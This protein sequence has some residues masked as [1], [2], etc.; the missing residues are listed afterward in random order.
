MLN[1]MIVYYNDG[2]TDIFKSLNFGAF[3]L[4]N[5]VVPMFGAIVFDYDQKQVVILLDQVKKI[6]FDLSEE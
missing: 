3:D 6:E 1:D 4:E 2:E 5:V